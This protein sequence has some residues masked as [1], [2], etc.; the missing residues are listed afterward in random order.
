MEERLARPVRGPPQ[1]YRGFRDLD[2]LRAHFPRDPRAAT[3]EDLGHCEGIEDRVWDD[4]G[5]EGCPTDDI[6]F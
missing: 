1:R 4:A 6:P 5:G 2:A 3:P